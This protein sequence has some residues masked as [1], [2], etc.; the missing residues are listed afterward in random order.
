MQYTRTFAAIELGMPALG[1]VSRLTKKL[2]GINADVRWIDAEQLHLTVKFL[3]EIENVALPKACSALRQVCASVEPFRVSFG[4]VGTFPTGKPPRVV[5]VG[6]TEGV[7][8]LQA[9]QTKLD[10]AMQDLGVPREVRAF[11]PHIT[12]GRVSRAADSNVLLEQLHSVADD[13]A[14]QAEVDEVSLLA[15][16]KER[17][18]TIYEPI[19]VAELG[20]K[21]SI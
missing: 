7:E 1:V 20:Q 18:R 16:V 6:I 19:D 2:S 4:G 13:A 12:I 8:S 17:R 11:S 3:G 15:S 9:L 10:E 14:T 5:W 21:H